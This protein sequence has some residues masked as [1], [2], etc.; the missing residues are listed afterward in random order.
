MIEPKKTLKRIYLPVTSID[1]IESDRN[2]RVIHDEE[3][4]EYFLAK[5]NLK[6]F[7]QNSGGWFVYTTGWVY[8]SNQ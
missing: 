1:W 5:N 6:D 8:S 7:L 2:T 3:G 4:V